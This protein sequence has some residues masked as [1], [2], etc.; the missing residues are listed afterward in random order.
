MLCSSK[1]VVIKQLVGVFRACLRIVIM[2]IPDH[3]PFLDKSVFDDAH[4][5]EDGPTDSRKLLT[6]NEELLRGLRMA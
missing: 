2:S 3:G 4:H 5:Q 1:I 6:R